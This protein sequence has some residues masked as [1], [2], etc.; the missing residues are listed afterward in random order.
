[1]RLLNTG[2]VLPGRAIPNAVFVALGRATFEYPLRCYWPCDFWMPLS[3]YL[4]GR[5][6]IQFSL[7]L[8]GRLLNT[9]FAVIGRAT[10]EYRYRSPWPGDSRNSFCCPWSGNLWIPSSLLLAVRLLNTVIVLF[11]GR[12]Q[13]QFL[14][15]LVGRL[16][17]T[18]S[19]VIGRATSENRY[20]SSWPGDPKYSFVALSRAT[21]GYPLR[22]HWPCDFLMPL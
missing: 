6:Q 17:N 7:P 8:V 20:R 14:L 9:L 10:S 3:F 11:V 2:I 5:F 21:F 19:A 22:C 16:L 18:V 13:I 1:M 4:A 12:F 15:A